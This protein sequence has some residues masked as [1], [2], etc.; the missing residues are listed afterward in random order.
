MR[1]SRKFWGELFEKSFSQPAFKNFSERFS[2]F[3]DKSVTSH[4][5]TLKINLLFVFTIC[6]LF[7]AFAGN[8]TQL[9]AGQPSSGQGQPQGQSASS[10]GGKQQNEFYD[11]L[12]L[13]IDRR[14][15]QKAGGRSDVIMIVHCEPGHVTLFSIPRDTL[16][17]VGKHKD[18]INHAYAYGGVKMSKATIERF[19]KFKVDNYIALDFQT[20]L[21]TIDTIKLLTDDGRLIGAENLLMN[22]ENLLKW[23]RFRGVPTGDRRRAQRHQLFIKRVLQYAQDMYNH[24]PNL[25]AQCVKAGLKIADTDLTYE[26]VAELF[27]TYKNFDIENQLER[28]VLP[29]YGQS[30]YAANKNVPPSIYQ[31]ESMPDLSAIDNDPNLTPE[32]KAKKKAEALAKWKSENQLVSYYIPK[33]DWSL[34][35]YIRFYRSKGIR[36]NYV[37]ED[38]LRK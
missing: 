17:Q 10:Q 32:E 18:K 27:E 3:S 14:P 12:I 7:L 31:E 29:G 38:I 20:F 5:R 11:L 19:L 1:T 36:M 15:K 21:T 9:N 30:R 6:L 16:V 13:G 37:E 2:Y 4:K 26:H 34:V 28:Y 33:Y 24:Q 25:F 35:T 8:A 22:G 23:L